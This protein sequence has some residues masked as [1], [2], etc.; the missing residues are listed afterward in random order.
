MSNTEPRNPRSSIIRAF[1]Q[2]GWI[3]TA[4]IIIAF[5]YV[6]FTILAPWQLHKNTVL[7]ER[8]HHIE[9]AFSTE[10]R[11]LFDVFSPDGT[12]PAGHEYQRVQLHGHYL[13]ESEVVMRVRP[14]EA[15]PAYH[16]LTPFQVDQGPVVLVNRG[17]Q[18]PAD[19]KIPE[20]FTPAPTGEVTIIALARPTEP[21]PTNAPIEDAGRRYVHGINTAEISELTH[22]PL[23]HDYVQLSADQPG[24]LTPFPLPKLDTGPHLSYGIQWIAFGIL[25]PIGLGYFVWAE[26]RERRREAAELAEL[27]TPTPAPAAQA[28]SRYG[29]KAT[30]HS[31]WARDDAE[32]F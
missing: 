31:R 15:G 28:R 26:L 6:A 18:R 5:T 3:A 1:L 11:P 17:W 12:L 7:T 32:R 30:P 14:V 16:A 10:P 24:V 13:P 23:L 20:S 4:L 25:A 2:P 27:A 8:N 21:K 9:A 19:G 29:D 22:T